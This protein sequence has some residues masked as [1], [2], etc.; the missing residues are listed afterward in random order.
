MS[1]IKQLQDCLQKLKYYMVMNG[2][3]NHIISETHIGTLYTKKDQIYMPENKYYQFT[4]VL[5][6]TTL[7][8]WE[9]NSH[10]SSEPTHLWNYIHTYTLSCVSHTYTL[11]TEICLE[12]EKIWQ[13]QCCLHT[14]QWLIYIYLWPIWQFSASLCIWNLQ[15]LWSKYLDKEVQSDEKLNI[16]IC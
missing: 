7:H 11:G 16:C 8:L 6:K 14:A 4:L 3:K 2:D 9:C 10:L 15:L 1:R 13:K 5:K 12:K